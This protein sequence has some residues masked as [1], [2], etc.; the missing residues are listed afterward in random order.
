MLI[1]IIFAMFMVTGCVYTI[2]HGDRS[3]RIVAVT[4]AVG[5][6]LTVFV[7]VATPELWQSSEPGILIVDIAMFAIF[8]RVVFKSEDFWPIWT[9]A[10]QLLSVLAHLG[11]IVRRG[12][13][14]VPF[15]IAEQAWAWFIIAQLII[16]TRRHRIGARPWWPLFRNRQN[17]ID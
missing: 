1:P 6:V 13:I 5:S 12:D 14:A 3:A 9:A 2:L 16:V 10:A 11:P 4:V 15:A 17:A 7:A 8:M